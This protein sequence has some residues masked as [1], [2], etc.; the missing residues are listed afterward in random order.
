MEAGL[1]QEAESTPLS[2]EDGVG[3]E[4]DVGPGKSLL[5]WVQPEFSMLTFKMN[6]AIAICWPWQN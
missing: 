6:F 4:A 3:R 5:L 2:G 1:L